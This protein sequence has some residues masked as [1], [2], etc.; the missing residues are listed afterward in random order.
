MK[1]KICFI[2]FFLFP[3]FTK[4]QNIV[5][6]EKIKIYLINSNAKY[7]SAIGIEDFKANYQYYFETSGDI[8]YKMFYDYNDCIDKLKTKTSIIYERETKLLNSLVE[9]QFSE[10]KVIQI[11]FDIKGN[12]YFMGDWHKMN[13]ELYY[14]LFKYFSNEILPQ[15]ILGLSRKLSRG[16]FWYE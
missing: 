9:L 14:I 2:L 10:Q 1:K 4:S 6:I 8:L 11:Y 13:N 7:R 15:K 5:E 16:D 12:Y 3:I